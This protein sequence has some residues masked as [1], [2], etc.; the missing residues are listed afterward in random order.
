MGARTSP[1]WGA[2]RVWRGRT[3]PRGERGPHVGQAAGQRPGS[4]SDGASGLGLPASG[5][6]PG[7][8]A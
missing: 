1:P 8:D 7:Q 4:D 5:A 3:P 6:Q 2:G